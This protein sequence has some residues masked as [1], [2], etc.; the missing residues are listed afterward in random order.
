[1]NTF[2]WLPS[3]HTPGL[4]AVTPSRPEWFHSA[5][6]CG[7]ASGLPSKDGMAQCGEVVASA[8]L[9]AR[10]GWLVHAPPAL[11]G[12]GSDHVIP[13]DDIG[14]ALTAYPHRILYALICGYPGIDVGG[15]QWFCIC[16]RSHRKDV[17]GIKRL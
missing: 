5:V 11:F 4:R 12:P 6:I 17:R 15:I 10:W 2:Q 3:Y 1:V 9:L 8:E 7:Y 14:L 13:G 16:V